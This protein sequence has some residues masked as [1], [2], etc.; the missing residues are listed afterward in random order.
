MNFSSSQDCTPREEGEV[1]AEGWV[2]SDPQPDE[3]NGW[4]DTFD[5][6]DTS[7]W[8]TYELRFGKHR[9]RYLLS[10]LED[11]RERGYLRYLLNW[12]ELRPHSRNNIEAAII[13]YE[14]NK[15]KYSNKKGGKPRKQEGPIPDKNGGRSSQKQS[16]PKRLTPLDLKRQNTDRKS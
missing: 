2:S 9:G 13:Y 11:P 3:K 4:T 15:Q 14:A 12:D 7:N 1:P 8:K 10:M 16:Q 6:T 5:V